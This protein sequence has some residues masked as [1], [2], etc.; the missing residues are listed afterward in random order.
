MKCSA[1]GHT[2]RQSLVLEP[3]LKQAFAAL[4]TCALVG[5]MVAGAALALPKNGNVV[6]G[7]AQIGAAGPKQLEIHQATD[8]AVI[9]WQSFDI[10]ADE[11]V[12][13]HQPSELSSL[14]NRVLGPN[15]TSILGSLFANGQVVLVNPRGITFGPGSHVD[16][17]SLIATT[18]N[19]PDS[20][21]M[22]GRLNFSE[23]GDPNAM[24][25]N[26]GRITAA[27]GG[28]VAPGV[29]NDGIITA[30]LGKV[31]LAAG[32]KFTL[33]LYGDD[34]VR[35]AVD[36][37]V[38]SE[39]LGVD[40]EV[41]EALVSNSRTIEADGG[42]VQIGAVA[43][44]G[45]VDTL[46]NIDGYVRAESVAEQDGR[47]VFLGSGDGI[48]QVAGEVDASG[49]EAGE[50]G[51]VV[52]VLGPKVA[53]T[54]DAVIDVS[55]AAGGGE[56]LIG[57]NFQGNGAEPNAERTYVGGNTSIQ[58][59]A[60]ANGDGGR[61]IVWADSD[62][63]FYGEI[64]AQ[65][66]APGG[67]GGFVEVSGKE[68]L[69][70]DGF[71]DISAPY[72]ANGTLLLDP[73]EILITDGGGGAN[74]AEISDGQVLFADGG[75]VFTISED[76]LETASASGS[77]LL[78]AN[79]SIVINDLTDDELTL[80]NSATFSSG[81]VFTMTDGS[82]NLHVTSGDLSITADNMTLG[83]V[84]VDAGD[85]DFVFVGAERILS[86][87]NDVDAGTNTITLTDPFELTLSDGNLIAGTII[88][89]AVNA[90]LKVGGSGVLTNSSL[91]VMTATLVTATT[92]GNITLDEVSSFSTATIQTLDLFASG[93]TSDITVEGT[94]EFPQIV[95]ENNLILRAK[96]DINI[97]DDLSSVM[98]TI[99][100]R[101]DSDGDGVGT[102]TV[103]DART[104]QTD[105]S[106]MAITAAD[107]VLD[108]T[109]DAGSGTVT[110]Q[111][112]DGSTIRLGNAGAGL[113][114]SAAELE[115]ITS[116][117]LQVGGGTTDVIVGTLDAMNTAN[118]SQVTLPTASGEI[119]LAGDYTTTAGGLTLD[120]PVKLNASPVTVDV[121]ANSLTITG[122]LDAANPGVA[123]L[124]IL[125]NGGGTADLQGIVGGNAALSFFDI[126]G[127]TVSIVGVSTTGSQD[128]A[129]TTINMS[130]TY[131][132]NGGAFTAADQLTLVGS[133]SIV[134]DNGMLDLSSAASGPFALTLDAGT[135]TVDFSGGTIDVA[136]L[137][138][139]GA[140]ILPGDVNTTGAQTYNG[141]LG[142]DGDAFTTGGG[143]FTL[144]GTAT[145]SPTPIFGPNTITTS[146]GNIVVNGTI[147]GTNFLTLDAGGGSV[148]V[149]NVGTLDALQ[150]F[151][152]TGSSVSLG[153][154]FTFTAQSYSD[155][156]TL[157]GTYIPLGNTFTA[158]ST[159]ALAGATLIDTAGALITF[160]G[161]I[162]GP[163]S[164]TINTAG[165]LS[166]PGSIG[167]STALASL[168]LTAPTLSLGNVATS[169][170]QSY[171]G[172]I[173][174]NSTYTTTGGAFSVTGDRHAEQCD[175]H[176]H[177]GRQRRLRRHDPGPRPPSGSTPVAG[178]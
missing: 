165:V 104:L 58:A 170:T 51:G 171:T 140:I 131:D 89:D 101:A 173:T 118:F 115:K 127:T 161:A 97:N 42:L 46:I 136:S 143:L 125:A 178:A 83:D 60:L 93:S 80:A 99:T 153:S 174:F 167:Q 43:A 28:L 63:R 119:Q 123:G 141:A 147:D 92:T 91:D 116:D 9:E 65:G 25:L 152:A 52:K 172:A 67:D 45:V 168:D 68:Q 109:V 96:D 59:D 88:V 78:Q 29:A 5:V 155:P 47:I 158:S 20:D 98:G 75:A 40:G 11:L 64:T 87:G 114:L 73:D 7:S 177:I 133:T 17:G 38:L 50:T 72:G 148:S 79:L 48:V 137:T 10:G 151:S 102:L 18:I 36:G 134:T 53:L 32:N 160:G 107:V 86:L 14:L 26:Q 85:F 37:A 44:K 94:G 6:A 90:D 100:V 54:G 2:R 13:I 139:S 145:M 112:S 74:D 71:V 69:A 176:F 19:I 128:F 120:R 113:Q 4:P 144:N 111:V 1:I 24:V 16:V 106:A 164:L 146:G 121:G 110:V 49:Q 31:A 126:S 163:G 8:K 39:V 35:I 142:M 15:G 22:A 150:G 154:V 84:T 129:G 23:P 159:V 66:G 33:D 175:H 56:A 135:N 27:E 108:G 77:V 41:L 149:G 122:A 132:T 62:T 103:A 81:G 157:N 105:D 57:G 124:N 166:L 21:F 30:R 130:G 3:N 95:A 76:A 162:D 156:L 34:L 12:T 138:A 61:V 117:T 82:D 55:G 169:G 70:F